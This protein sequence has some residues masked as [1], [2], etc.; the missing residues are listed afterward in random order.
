MCKL[1]ETFFHSIDEQ[2]FLRRRGNLIEGGE[3]GVLATTFIMH[4]ALLIMH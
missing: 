4:Y 1:P 2:H 3:P